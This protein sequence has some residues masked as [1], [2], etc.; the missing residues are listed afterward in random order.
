MMLLSFKLHLRV[1]G[2]LI[3]E[4][5]GYQRKISPDMIPILEL[6]FLKR[7]FTCVS[8]CKYIFVL[9]YLEICS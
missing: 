8:S 2:Q 9:K 4:T 5:Y 6:E 7:I 1:V 3:L